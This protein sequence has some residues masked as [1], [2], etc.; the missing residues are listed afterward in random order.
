MG[1]SGNWKVSPIWPIKIPFQ[2][3]ELADDYTYTVIGYPNRQYVWIMS[4]TPTM[5]EETYDMLK[6]LLQKKHQYKLDNLRK[7]P[8]Q[9][10]KNEREKRGFTTN[11]IPDELLIVQEDD[12]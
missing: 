11:E 2:V 8:H 4:R 3:I 6:E 12:K 7:V 9:W 10:T 5:N 1:K